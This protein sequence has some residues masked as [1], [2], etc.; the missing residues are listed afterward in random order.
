[1]AMAGAMVPARPAA[2]EVALRLLVAL[3][4]EALAV[5]VARPLVTSM[6][7]ICYFSFDHLLES[8]TATTARLTQVTTFTSLGLARASITASL[9]SFSPSTAA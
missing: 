2:V 1:M 7:N 6:F 5:V 4:A 3:A 8:A 9:K